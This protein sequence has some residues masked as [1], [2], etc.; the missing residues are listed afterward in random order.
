MPKRPPTPQCDLL[1]SVS[2][3]RRTIQNFIDWCYEQ[4]KNDLLE[5]RS[6]ELI[7]GFLEIDPVELENERQALL[8][9]QWALN[10]MSD[11]K[12]SGST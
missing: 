6:D 5:Y 9:Y 1:R 8:D 11:E 10:D 4:G 12:P 2:E 7:Y 3:K